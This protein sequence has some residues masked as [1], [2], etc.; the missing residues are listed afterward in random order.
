MA[1]GISVRVSTK[2]IVEALS[3]K[4]QN[5]EKEKKAA[6]IA[7]QK[8]EKEMQN[9]SERIMQILISEKGNISNMHVS[10]A[11]RSNLSC[12]VSLSFIG[13]LPN[14]PAAPAYTNEFELDAQKREIEQVLRILTM[15]DDETI[16]A[17]TYRN[18]VQYL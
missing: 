13:V 17:S 11:Y 7:Q 14:R 2:K 9:W 5:I 3:S 10:P 4:L 12:G 15:T 6:K 8:H 16:N 18:V 1:K